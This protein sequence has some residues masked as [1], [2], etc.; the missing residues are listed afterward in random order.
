MILN[1]DE[2]SRNCV[3]CNM[4]DMWYIIYMRHDLMLQPALHCDTFKKMYHISFT[5]QSAGFLFFSFSFW[6]PFRNIKHKITF[7]SSF[8][9]YLLF[10]RT[11]GLKYI[12]Y[13]ILANRLLGILIITNA[14]PDF[15]FL[16]TCT[17]SRRL[18]LR[19][20]WLDS[21]RLFYLSQLNQIYHTN[22][23]SVLIV[24]NVFYTYFMIFKEKYENPYYKIFTINLTSEIYINKRSF[25]FINTQFLIV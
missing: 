2:K 23:D 16:L 3:L 18:F 22:R 1:F 6:N 7:K 15:I 17:H 9:Q 12:L 21:I 14:F 19:N 8:L 25:F 4:I 24:L 5:I 11:R 13:E 10:S 20:T